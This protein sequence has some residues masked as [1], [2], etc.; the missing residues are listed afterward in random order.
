MIRRLSPLILAFALT[1]CSG[2][3][4]VWLVEMGTLV[5]E[6]PTQTVEHN[7]LNAT[8]EVDEPDDEWTETT[9]ADASPQLM[10]AEIFESDGGD[11]HERVM[12]ADGK[13]LVGLK[14]DAGLWVFAWTNHE[15]GES[16]EAHVSGYDY[17]EG[18]EVTVL[19][20]VTLDLDGKENVGTFDVDVQAIGTFSETDVFSSSET[21]MGFGQIPADAYLD[22]TTEGVPVFNAA[23]TTECSGTPCTLT[24]TETAAGSAPVTA[25]RTNMD[26]DG[27]DGVEG[28]GQ[29]GGIPEDLFGGGGR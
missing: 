23:D 16:S 28:S 26:P 24:V 21:G 18:Q 15:G 11:A 12:V 14:D 27:F 17:T 2:Y 22:S 8:P 7:F 9:T 5:T 1:G 4:A 20:T 25:Y 10:F 3:S 6:D 13:T 19:W 29:E